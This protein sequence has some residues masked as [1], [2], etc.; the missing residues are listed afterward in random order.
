MTGTDILIAPSCGTALE[1]R[2]IEDIGFSAIHASGS[3]AHQQ[4]G[5]QDAGLLS[6]TEMVQR[7][8]AL[9]DSVD[10]PI[11]ADM[12]TGFG[13]VANVV[14]SVRDYERAGAAAFH[15]EDTVAKVGFAENAAPE[16]ISRTEMVNKIKAA[17]DTRTDESMIIIARSENRTDLHEFVERN[18]ECIEA[19]ADGC[20]TSGSLGE[21]GIQALRQAVGPRPCFV[22]VLPRGMSG[23][24]FRAWGANCAVLPGML[25]LVAL[26][27]QRQLLTHLKTT[28][29]VVGYVEGIAGIEETRK[30]TSRVGKAEF[31][32]IM[33]RFGGV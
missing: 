28:G 25:A 31:E 13:N 32:S 3:V 6:V 29:T 30:F 1:A 26:H 27:A 33:Q 22:G 9:C 17:V 23:P 14:R 18:A 8:T 5:Y 24:D 4:A 19:G 2:Q 10:I 16:V 21:E 12:D 7:I 15:L 20:W 11:I